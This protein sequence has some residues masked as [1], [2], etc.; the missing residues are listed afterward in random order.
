M[1]RVLAALI[2]STLALSAA[3]PVEETSARR[4]SSAQ[5][6]G[7]WLSVA[8][9]RSDGVVVPFAAYW[10]GFWLTPWPAPEG[11]SPDSNSV[12][13]LSEA[14][15]T[16]DEKFTTDWYAGG[17]SRRAAVRLRAA[18]LVEVDN[19]CQKNWGLQTN[20]RG[21]KHK[22]NEHH[23]NV[24][25]A[26]SERREIV[27]P[28]KLDAGAK[29]LNVVRSQMLRHFEEAEED[30]LARPDM[31]S[32]A[33]SFPARAERVRRAPVVVSLY[34]VELGGGRRLYYFE[35]ERRYPKPRGAPDA[36]CEHVSA[37]NGMLLQTNRGAPR[38]VEH[39]F[40]LSDCDG[41][42]S[43][44]G[45]PLGL[46]RDNRRE[47]LIM[48]EHGYEDENYAIMELLSGGTL[49]RLRRIGGGGC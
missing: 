29:N 20:Y 18:R 4:A 46:I 6:P 8:V 9:L 26:L 11:D 34:R 10:Q 49:R 1:R 48:Q 44:R 40:W 35:A 12:A 30:W 23:R 43:G 14:W 37:L 28:A 42:E 27:A 16:R 47:F 25:L 7:E 31:A 32:R 19:H 39:Q 33:K 17:W 21:T 45:V 5:Q 15:F 36:N 41:K 38:L 13:N 22:P 3:G 24:G 2:V